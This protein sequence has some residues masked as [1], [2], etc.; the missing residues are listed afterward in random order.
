M[1]LRLHL[2]HALILLLLYITLLP[3]ALAQRKNSSN[4]SLVIEIQ[5]VSHSKGPYR[6]SSIS[7]QRTSKDTL[8]YARIGNLNKSVPITAA[9]PIEKSF[10]VYLNSFFNHCPTCTPF[11]MV[12]QKIELSE[13]NESGSEHSVAAIEAD[14]YYT[15]STGTEVRFFTSKAMSK[16]PHR[17]ATAWL[18]EE[19]RKALALT[20][21]KFGN[22]VENSQ[23]FNSTNSSKSSIAKKEIC[24]VEFNPL[25][26]RFML[27]GKPN[28][29]AMVMDKIDSNIDPLLY[30]ELEKY[31]SS[32]DIGTLLGVLGGVAIGLVAA[33]FIINDELIPGLLIGGAV[34]TLIGLGVLLTSKEAGRESARLYNLSLGIRNI[35]SST[36]QKAFVAG[37]KWQF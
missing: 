19:L 5:G 18:E 22:A 11:S 2:P 16:T 7:D 29:T 10:E 33:Q 8:G 36:N 3:S 13:L 20:L 15:D 4:Y 9:Q 17:D 6:I 27:C 25:L 35:E 34:S 24:T 30:A 1:Y 12:I 37:Y 14:F 28:T 21:D 31:K 26:N 32:R 23:L